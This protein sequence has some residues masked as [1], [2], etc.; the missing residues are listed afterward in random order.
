MH[1]RETENLSA[2]AVTA[3][4][5]DATALLFLMMLMKK[6]IKYFC[7]SIITI[8]VVLNHRLTFNR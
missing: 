8:L 3:R 2:E 7:C 4:L 5:N 6:I 1:A